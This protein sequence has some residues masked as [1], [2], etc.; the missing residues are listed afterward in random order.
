MKLALGNSLEGPVFRF[1]AIPG[2]E[3]R[4][5]FALPAIQKVSVTQHI[6]ISSTL[7]WFLLLLKQLI[8]RRKINLSVRGNMIDSL[9]QNKRSESITSHRSASPGICKVH[10]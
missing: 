8:R 3:I 1:L 2:L 10:T 6:L 7:E 5:N 4:S 9:G